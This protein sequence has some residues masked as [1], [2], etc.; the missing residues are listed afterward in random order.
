MDSRIFNDSGSPTPVFVMGL[1]NRAT[2]TSVSWF[3]DQLTAAGYRVQAIRLPT[4]I[5]DFEAEYCRPVQRS[6]DEAHPA[7]VVGHSL[8]GLVMAFLESSARMVYLSPWWGI[9]EGKVSAWERWLVPRLPLE[10]RILPISIRREELGDHLSDAEWEQ[11]PRRIS[12]V[13]ISAVYSAQQSRPPIDE[14][15]VVLLSLR[16]TIV[17][18]PAVGKAVSADQIRLYDGGH[19]LFAAG[20][21]EEAI[22]EVLSVLPG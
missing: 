21:R 1:G 3:I 2:D 15:A 11:V 22:A 16:D 8:G 19:Q 18:L 10:A 20:G 7:A 6:L 13:F 17:S 9:D 4:D 5:T 14:D 12:P